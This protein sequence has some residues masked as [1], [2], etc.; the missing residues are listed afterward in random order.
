[1]DRSLK[2][3]QEL[4]TV[5]RNC[6]VTVGGDAVHTDAAHDLASLIHCLSLTL[7]S[8]P[9]EALNGRAAVPRGAAGGRTATAAVADHGRPEASRA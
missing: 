8:C 3:L 1:M 5:S 9:H 6:K 4:A 7:L 2:A